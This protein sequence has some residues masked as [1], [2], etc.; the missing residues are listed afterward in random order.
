MGPSMQKNNFEEQMDAVARGESLMVIPRNLQEIS[1]ANTHAKL[2]SSLASAG[3]PRHDAMMPLDLAKF[4]IKFLTRP[5]DPVYDPF[6]GSGTTGEAAELL[7]R[8]WL[9]SD[10]SLAHI[11]GS[12]LNFKNPNFQ[13]A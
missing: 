12:A 13:P 11:L 9:G 3:L 4:F 2:R 5:G 8:N 7:G 1:N 10:A 6:H